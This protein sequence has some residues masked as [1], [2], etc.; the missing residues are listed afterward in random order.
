MDNLPPG[1]SPAHPHLAGPRECSKCHEDVM[2][3]SCGREFCACSK[4]HSLQYELEACEWCVLDQ[5]S[6]RISELEVLDRELDNTIYEAQRIAGRL[7]QLRGKRAIVEISTAHVNAVGE[8]LDR[9][10]ALLEEKSEAV[11]LS[12]SVFGF[13]LAERVLKL[14]IAEERKRNG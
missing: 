11:T 13:A 7:L 4:P 9:L 6:K 14:F 1:V 12:G 2:V 8:L 5:A 10:E 3:C